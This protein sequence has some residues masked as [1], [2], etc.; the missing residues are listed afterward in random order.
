VARGR[1]PTDRRATLVS[2]TDQG[3]AAAARLHA[4]CQ[5]GVRVLLGDIPAGD[6]AT[7]VKVLD[8]VLGR[9][10]GA[11]AAAPETEGVSDRSPSG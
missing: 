8:H 11:T 3:V 4:D 9:L 5:M 10:G 2:L 6:L 7:F 1:H